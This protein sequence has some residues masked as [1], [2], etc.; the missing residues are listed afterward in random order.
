MERTDKHTSPGEA[1][2]FH[3][4]PPRQG[5]AP[6][7]AKSPHWL[8]SAVNYFSLTQWPSFTNCFLLL[9]RVFWTVGLWVVVVALYLSLFPL[10]AVLSFIFD[11]LDCLITW[12]AASVRLRFSTSECNMKVMRGRGQQCEGGFWNPCVSFWWV[13]MMIYTGNI[14]VNNS[15]V[16]DSDISTSAVTEV[17]ENH[18]K[19]EKPSA[20]ISFLFFNKTVYLHLKV[21]LTCHRLQGNLKKKNNKK[22]TFEALSTPQPYDRHF[23]TLFVA[24]NFSRSLLHCVKR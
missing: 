1:A 10:K 5:A 20:Q 9:S 16:T 2:L 7:R 17:E 18:S 24:Q 12:R 19:H 13:G 6:D 3:L 23:F 8:S 22:Q 15:I 21:L 11:L 14:L 4:P